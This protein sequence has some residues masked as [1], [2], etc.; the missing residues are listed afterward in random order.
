MAEKVVQKVVQTVYTEF[1][2]SSDVAKYR[3]KCGKHSRLKATKRWKAYL[4]WTDQ[5]TRERKNKVVY[6]AT[7]PSR[8]MKQDA[9][10]TFEKQLIAE[11]ADPSL[12]VTRIKKYRDVDLARRAKK[13]QLRQN[14]VEE[15]NYSLKRLIKLCTNPSDDKGP[16]TWRDFKQRVETF[17]YDLATWE[18]R[19]KRISPDKQRHTYFEMKRICQIAVKEEL[20]NEQPLQNNPAKRDTKNSK[21]LTHTYADFED[22]LLP[23][24]KDDAVLKSL[25]LLC[26]EAGL[27]LG[28][29]RGLKWEDIDWGVLQVED[30][31]EESR[32]SDAWVHVKR[33]NPENEV[34]IDED[35]TKTPAGQRHVPIN[36]AIRNS[37]VELHPSGKTL[38][39][40]MPLLPDPETEQWQPENYIFEDKDGNV[41]SRS[42][43]SK[44]LKKKLN[45]AGLPDRAGFQTLRR[46]FATW[47]ARQGIDPYRLQSWMGHE[48]FETTNRFYIGLE[49]KIKPE[50][51]E[52]RFS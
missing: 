1:V 47:C 5:T 27:R 50:Y 39:K 32:V 34:E 6:F 49:D 44:R 10:E 22:K 51:Y 9:I 24:L 41:P 42:V 46:S 15:I 28:E 38:G 21:P 13:D 45:Q 52:N 2:A 20:I 29:A 43:L 36:L 37:L 18:Y 4:S 8:K 12:V 16:Y 11:E 17:E 48:S 19:D 7:E 25:V 40:L 23:L 30:T 3:V 26:A 35:R 14:T 33:S 31:V